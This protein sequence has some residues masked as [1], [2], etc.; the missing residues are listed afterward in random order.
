MVRYKKKKQEEKNFCV[1]MWGGNH[2]N[3]LLLMFGIFHVML[4]YQ[5]NESQTGKY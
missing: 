5:L 3:V 4:C 2:F 1:C